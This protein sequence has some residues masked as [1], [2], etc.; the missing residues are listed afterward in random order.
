M[1]AG[2]ADFVGQHIMVDIPG[3]EIS[4]A[5]EHLVREGRIGGVILFAK[6]IRSASQVRALTNDL[7]RLAATTGLPPLLISVD[8][9]GGMVNRLTEGVTI[10]PS[11]MALGATGRPQDAAAAGRITALELRRLGINTNHAPVLDVNTNVANPIIGARAFSDDADLV[12]RFGAAYVTAAEAAGILTTPKH[13]PGHGAT[14]L[15]SHLDLPVVNKDATTLHREEIAP[16]R[17]AIEVGAGGVMAAHIVYSAF[18][19]ERP[20]TL[21]S[22]V[23]TRL[24]REELRFR[25]VAFTD[26]MD[27]KAVADRWP[28]GGAA[29]AALA[30]GADVVMACGGGA[31]QW[32]S[33][34]ALRA[35]AADG[36][37][38]PDLMRHSGER[39]ATAKAHYAGSPAGLPQ[40]PGTPAFDRSPHEAT[41]QEIA[42]RA[43]TLVRNEGQRVPLPPGPTAVL[44]VGSDDWVAA[45]PHLGAELRSLI[46]EVTV[47]ATPSGVSGRT[48]A[49]VVVV[50]LSW[51]SYPGAA[52]IAALHQEF[53][54]RL[55]VVGA[56]NP[57]ELLRFPEVAT[58]LAA[59][60]PDPPS[61][62]AAARILAGALRPQGSLPVSLPPLYPRGHRA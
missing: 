38:H 19:S 31:V 26:S 18:D 5:V 3:A 30:A 39:I 37:L 9:E 2:I 50:S 48:W 43:V 57:Y 55:V 41:A 28:R 1:K 13:F 16:F 7:Q 22:A 12:G 6:N 56:G 29:V 59:Y 24:L 11:A 23:L 15:D 42:D 33:I 58:Y 8:Q 21:S 40:P 34:E 4:P 47:A 27:M 52:V 46:P 62:R 10:F 35:A 60:G 54:E 44:Q 51:R 32:A 36:T 20:A 17:H 49:S 61:M 45:P 25:G 53:G 14:S